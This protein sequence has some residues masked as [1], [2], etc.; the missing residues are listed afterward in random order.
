VEAVA[1]HDE[2]QLD[3]WLDLLGTLFDQP[4]PTFPA[5]RLAAEFTA[6]VELTAVSWNQLGP[7]EVAIAAWTASGDPPPEHLVQQWLH[8]FVGDRSAHPLAN[9]Y[10]YTREVEPRTLGRLP[11]SVVG[12]RL[13]DEWFEA[14]SPWGLEHHLAIPLSSDASGHQALVLARGHEDFDPGTLTLARR[15]RPL[16]SALERQGRFLRLHEAP[17]PQLLQECALTGRELVV[18]RL[19]ATGLTVDQVGHRLHRSPRTVHKQ[20]ESVYAKL[21]VHDRVSA[22]MT[23]QRLG[24]LGPRTNPAPIKG[25]PELSE[26]AVVAAAGA[27]QAFHLKVP[28]AR[29]ASSRR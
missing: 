27:G 24:L 20:V 4:E 13:L 26:P 15:L 5:A 2:Q 21:R 29:A 22:V 1:V 17:P 28:T 16:L 14:T 9:W 23:A 7:R 6:T 12:S 18:L 11:A 19:L 25:A 8:R 10:A 3:R